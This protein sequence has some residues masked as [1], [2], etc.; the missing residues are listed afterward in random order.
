MH[1]IFLNVAYIQCR[2][3][4][5]GQLTVLYN[6]YERTGNVAFILMQI[7]TP[8]YCF[9]KGPRIFKAPYIYLFCP[10]GFGSGPRVFKVG[11][12]KSIR[13]KNRILSPWFSINYDKMPFNRGWSTCSNI[14]FWLR[15]PRVFCKKFNQSDELSICFEVQHRFKAYARQHLRITK[16]A[17]HIHVFMVTSL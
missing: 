13:K 8:K 2:T 12:Q 17:L 3:Y 7:R 6:R 15:A 5:T 9:P 1:L 11:G 14:Q 4:R 16:W 10:P